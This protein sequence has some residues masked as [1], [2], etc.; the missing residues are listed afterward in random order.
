MASVM[1][2]LNLNCCLKA[3]VLFT[4]HPYRKW[5]SRFCW[6]CCLGS[7]CSPKRTGR[8]GLHQLV[9]LQTSSV[10]TQ[11]GLQACV[12]TR[13]KLVSPREE[14]P[15]SSAL[16]GG[17]AHIPTPCCRDPCPQDAWA[18]GGSKGPQRGARHGEHMNAGKPAPAWGDGLHRKR[19][20]SVW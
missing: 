20:E 17:L 7:G 15:P 6:K 14:C 4:C 8:S 16:Y 10:G 1:V 13:H 18:Q 9:A 2:S 11:D 12:S 5:R 19:R 3:W